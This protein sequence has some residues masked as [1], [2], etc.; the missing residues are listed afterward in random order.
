M[1][2][3][4][5]ACGMKLLDETFWEAHWRWE[6]P[7]AGLCGAGVLFLCGF[8]VMFRVIAVLRQPVLVARRTLWLF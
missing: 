8:W 4:A 5:L 1:I 2:F 3:E 7:W 6:S